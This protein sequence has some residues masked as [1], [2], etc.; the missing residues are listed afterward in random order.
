V[1]IRLGCLDDGHAPAEKAMLD[2]IRERSGREPL[3][4]VKTLL[5]RGEIFGTPFSEELDDVM[6]G[7]SEWSAGERELF[8]GLASQL[9][10]CLF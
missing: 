4:V 10:Q 2:A 6:R 9:N 5:Y 1:S 8:A 7:P 3:G